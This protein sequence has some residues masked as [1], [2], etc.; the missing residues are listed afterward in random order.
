MPPHSYYLHPAVRWC[1]VHGFCIFLDVYRDRYLSLPIQ[2]IE[3]LLPYLDHMVNSPTPMRLGDIPE[4]LLSIANQLLAVGILTETPRA[5]PRIGCRDIS[6]PTFLLRRRRTTYRLPRYPSLLPVFLKACTFAHVAL[7]Y[8]PLHRILSRI[9]TRRD[10]EQRAQIEMG[11]PAIRLALAFH[12]LRP[13]YPHAYLCMFDSLAMLN[14]LAH[15]HVFPAWV[16][17]V[18][19][20]PFEAHCWVQLGDQVIC[21]TP[22]FAASRFVPIMAL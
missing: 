17:G 11:P 22:T 19:A 10:H 5:I 13:L 8:L 6:P 3:P 18:S 7:R 14:F 9:A 2:S 21:D 12:A 4:Q 20:D 16:F 1:S 15:W